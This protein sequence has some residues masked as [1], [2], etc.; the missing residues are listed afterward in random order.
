MKRASE[1]CALKLAQISK[2]CDK[3]CAVPAQKPK[4]SNASNF[5]FISMW[6]AVSRFAEDVQDTVVQLVSA[7]TFA[8]QF[9]SLLNELK[10]E[11]DPLQLA[12]SAKTSADVAELLERSL[13]PM[14][15]HEELKKMIGKELEE[16]REAIAKDHGEV[17]SKLEEVGPVLDKIYRD[18]R[19]A[20]D[21]I[22]IGQ[23]KIIALLDGGSDLDAKDLIEREFKKHQL[24]HEQIEYDEVEGYLG[25]GGFGLVYEGTF[26]YQKVAIKVSRKE[27]LSKRVM[28]EEK[29]EKR[30][31]LFMREIVLCK[32]LHHTYVVAKK[33]SDARAK[34]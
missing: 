22:L 20:F 25:C 15:G 4:D 3:Y 21:D 14:E 12:L 17:M 7:E 30:K 29:W 10:T 9:E 34:S 31:L 28:S 16:V 32:N 27:L 23:N 8:T 26:Q 11:M 18:Q 5:F 13:A 19:K 1:R 33:S 24:V 6:D 2:L